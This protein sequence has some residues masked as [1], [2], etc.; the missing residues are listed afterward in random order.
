MKSRT[1][2]PTPSNAILAI[3]PGFDRLGVAVLSQEGNKINLLFSECV[4]TSAKEP[5]AQRLLTI[6]SRIRVIIKKWQPTSPLVD[7]QDFRFVLCIAFN[8]LPEQ[9][10]EIARFAQR[11]WDDLRK[12]IKGKPIQVLPR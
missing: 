8:E 12:Q 2:T 1:S 9:R 4:R 7:Y 5:R 11:S 10:T 3:D 6:G